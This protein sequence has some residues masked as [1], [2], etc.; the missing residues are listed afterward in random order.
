MSC[1]EKIIENGTLVY[2]DNNSV[3]NSF[4]NLSHFQKHYGRAELLQSLHRIVDCALE[5]LLCN[6]LS[7]FIVILSDSHTNP[8]HSMVAS[9]IAYF[10]EAEGMLSLRKGGMTNK[11]C[12]RCQTAKDKST[13]ARACDWQNLAQ[14]IECLSL[15]E[16]KIPVK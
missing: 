2:Y 6:A 15:L 10:N 14:R 12:N 1:A 11:P 9:P 5:R 4:N 3:D 8:V 16:P 13:Q 7:E